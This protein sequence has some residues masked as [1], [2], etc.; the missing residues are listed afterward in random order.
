M[1]YESIAFWFLAKGQF[2][3]VS[4]EV[5]IRRLI[6]IHRWD[7]W[8]TLSG[9]IF[10][11]TESSTK[12]DEGCVQRSALVGW[13]QIEVQRL[14]FMRT[15]CLWA[16]T[17]SW[18]VIEIWVGSLTIKMTASST[19]L[20]LSMDILGDSKLSEF[21]LPHMDVNS[22]TRFEIGYCRPTPWLS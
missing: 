14:D 7:C 9:D 21:F 22:S 20:L 3:A 12:N 1:Y 10:F 8:V 16:K 17:L 5:I 4:W 2:Q 15:L 19:S 11:W 6:L 13:A 18:D